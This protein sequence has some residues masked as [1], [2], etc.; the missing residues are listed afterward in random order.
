MVEDVGLTI[1]V[2]Q[3]HNLQ[4]LAGVAVTVA[5]MVAPVYF[6]EVEATVAMADLVVAPALSTAAMVIPAAS[7]EAVAVDLL[8]A[9]VEEPVAALEADIRARHIMLARSA[10]EPLLPS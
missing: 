10:L 1:H 8:S 7:L 9:G 5:R 6:A 3:E 4:E 2:R